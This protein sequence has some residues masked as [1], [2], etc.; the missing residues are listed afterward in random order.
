M[1]CYEV[2]SDSVDEEADEANAELDRPSIVPPR[3]LPELV[4]GAVWHS[5]RETISMGFY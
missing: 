1:P 2:A 5:S 3:E 4:P